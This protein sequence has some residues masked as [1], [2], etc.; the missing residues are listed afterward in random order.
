MKICAWM[1]LKNDAYY[2]PMALQ[3]VLPYVTN[4][5]IQ[6][7][8]STDGS[9]EIAKEYESKYLNTIK[10]EVVDTGLDRFDFQYNEPYYRSLAIER[11]EEIFKPD[12]LLKLDAD[13][14]YTPYFFSQVASCEEG[15]KAGV[16]NSL[17]MSGERF[18][19]KTHKTASP[20]AIFIH[21]GVKFCDPHTH[22]WST[23]QRVRYVKNPDM[24]GS[25]L[26]CILAPN[27]E[28]IK[29]IP[30]ICNVHLHRTFGPKSLTFWGEGGDKF[31]KEVYLSGKQKFNAPVICPQWFN[32]EVN[33]GTAEQVDFEWPDYVLKKWEEWGIW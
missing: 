7:Q 12:Y 24:S 28:P 13:E 17:R 11:A 32:H 10:V 27:P 23:R 33:M 31:D 22:L 3:S 30:G 2:L 4:I 19:S 29:W 16:I 1:V 5:Y 15:F 8:G 18:I 14:I 25:F 26:H 9:L 20:H 6:D 21:N